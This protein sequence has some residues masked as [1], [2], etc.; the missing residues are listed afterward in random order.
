MKLCKYVCAATSVS[1][2]DLID[3]NNLQVFKTLSCGSVSIYGMDAQNNYLVACG[4]VNRAQGPMLAGFVNVYDLRTASQMTPVSFHAGAAFVQM[5]PRM[6]TTCIVASQSGQLQVI[7]VVN[8]NAIVLK[9]INIST[10]M[11][12]M[13][14]A[15]TGEALAV[16]DADGYIHLWGSPSKLQ[17]CEYTSQALEWGDTPEPVP[18]VDIDSEL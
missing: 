11:S 9:Q 13:V 1:T 7:D 3:P 8:P 14:L 6:S 16:S 4:W 12:N 10:Y 2:I 15:P 17:F 18:P 5:H